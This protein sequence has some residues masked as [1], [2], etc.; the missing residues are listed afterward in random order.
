LC[1]CEKEP[2]EEENIEKTL[3]I[4]LPSNR[5]LQHQYWVQSYQHYAD[6]IRDLL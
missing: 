4:I 2:S 1:F 3:Q 6:L 5:V